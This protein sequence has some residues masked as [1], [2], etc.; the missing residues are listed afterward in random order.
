MKQEKGLK[1]ISD[2]QQISKNDWWQ[3]VIDHPRGNIFQSPPYYEVMKSTPLYYPFILIAKNEG[4]ITGV[5]LVVVQKEFGW[6]AGYL[7]SRAIIM[8]GPLISKDDPEVLEIML[9]FYKEN[10][11]RHALYT[12]IRNL[13]DLGWAKQKFKENGFY[14]EEHLN[15]LISLNVSEEQ[16]NSAMHKSRKRNFI[17]ALNKGVELV[18]INSTDQVSIGFELIRETYERVML[19]YACKELFV[20]A[21]EKLKDQKLIKG[22]LAVHE[23]KVIGIRLV[24]LYKKLIY[25]WYAGSSFEERNKYPNDFLIYH[26]LLWGMKNGYEVFD[27]GGAGHPHEEYGVR[28]HKLK[29]GGK[30]V[31]FGRF[32][33]VHAPI[34]YKIISKSFILWRNLKKMT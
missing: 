33:L 16:L 19:P 18:E 26:I 13:H 20:R 6:F 3:F 27:F 32:Q 17:K 34:L 31:N 25:D 21:F 24:F 4:K 29:F 14:F 30:V 7:T 11:K 1:I 23:G 9:H 10:F 28:E 22:V 8:G 15:I 2:F 12:Q 5:M